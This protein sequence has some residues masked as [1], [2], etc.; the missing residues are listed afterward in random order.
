MPLPHAAT[1]PLSQSSS[2]GVLPSA[3]LKSVRHGSSIA[4]TRGPLLGRSYRARIRSTSALYFSISPASTESALR[5][6]RRSRC[7]SRSA[8]PVS[9]RLC[10]ALSCVISRTN[11]SLFSRPGHAPALAGDQVFFVA[12]RWATSS[13]FEVADLRF[14]ARCASISAGRPRTAP[15]RSRDAAN[16]DSSEMTRSRSR[17]WSSRNASNWRSNDATWSRAPSMDRFDAGAVPGEVLPTQVAEPAA[18]LALQV[19]EANA[20]ARSHQARSA[21]PWRSA[22]LVR[23][24]ASRQRPRQRAFAR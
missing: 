22:L 24:A 17:R 10:S 21:A 1:I 11:R 13:S 18:K 16:C 23:S 7:C 3:R 8:T 5:D 14:A 2:F 9:Q 19:S 6:P 20:L 4:H 12:L 15:K